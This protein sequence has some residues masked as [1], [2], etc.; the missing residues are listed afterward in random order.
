MNGG[1]GFYWDNSAATNH[2]AY[3]GNLSLN[4]IRS[5]NGDTTGPTKW[6]VYI[7]E[8]AS[9]QGIR[10]VSLNNCNL[11]ATC[12]GYYLRNVAHIS[13][14][15][16]NLSQLSGRTI[17]DVDGFRVMTWDNV[18]TNTTATTVGSVN[19][20]GAIQQWLIPIETGYT[21]PNHSV[22]GEGA[23]YGASFEAAGAIATHAA[24]PD[25]HHARGHS[26][27]GT[28]DHS[29]SNWRTFYSNGSG[30]VAEVALGAA[31]KVLTCNGVS[32]AP[33]FEYPYL[34]PTFSGA[35]PGSPATGQIW[36]RTDL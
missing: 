17:C 34:L 4:N 30:Q 12:E 10:N 26:M 11:N 7:T 6:S 8:H 16:T 20:N 22:W 24:L 13:V 18:W 31:G 28:S 1:D 36:L 19:V 23:A 29:A 21:Y 25:V 5:E 35:D 15:D 14:R 27:T 33:T 3:S 32:S 2:T 9:A